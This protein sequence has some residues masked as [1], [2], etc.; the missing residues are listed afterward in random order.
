MKY[1]FLTAI[2][3]V[4]F[5][6][7][8][9]IPAAHAEP[10]DVDPPVVTDPVE[11]PAPEIPVTDPPD[12]PTSGIP[13]LNPFTPG[14]TGTVMNYAEDG[15]GKVFYT[16]TTP[17][18]QVFYLVIDR[19]RSTDN[20]YFLNAVTVDDLMS[21]AVPSENSGP[22][23]SISGVPNTP[24]VTPSP[25]P[26]PTPGS[27]PSPEPAPQQGGGMGTPVLV[28]V[29][30]V[31]GGG[32]GWYFKIYRPKQQRAASAEAEF[33]TPDDEESPGPGEWDEADQWAEDDSGGG[34]D[35]Q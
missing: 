20:V 17:D 3:A 8:P 33:E 1:R 26:E 35:E 29:L 25:S 6:L 32:A 14:G 12:E 13:A 21:L 19:E 16:I 9:F 2:L 23:G 18:D 7:F 31:I 30:V 5:M 22:N 10:L 11:T 15:A 4:I 34:D 28:I 27:E 24:T